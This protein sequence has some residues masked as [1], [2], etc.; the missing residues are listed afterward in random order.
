MC[1]SDATTELN[2]SQLVSGLCKKKKK[3]SISE[4]YPTKY[5]T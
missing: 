1:F 5:D 2:Y 3:R 4:I